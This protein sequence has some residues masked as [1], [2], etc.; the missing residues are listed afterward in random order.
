MNADKI[1]PSNWKKIIQG[2]K[3][4]LYITGISSL[5]QGRRKYIEKMKWVFCVFQQHPE[6]V[7][8]WRPHP[9]ELSTIKSIAPELEQL[10]LEVKQQYQS[11]N[12]GILDESAD[13]HRAIAVSDAYYGIWSSVVHLYKFTQKPILLQNDNI[14]ENKA[15]DI[16][17]F[18]ID[19]EYVWYIISDLNILFR[20]DIE[21]KKSLDVIVL[22]DE[23][24]C[25]PFANYNM[26]K[27]FDKIFLIPGTG[28]N[29]IVYEMTSGSVSKTKFGQTTQMIKFGAV[30]L[31]E[32]FLYLFP[33]MGNEIWKYDLQTQK[34]VKKI[35]FLF[36][37]K[38]DR[39]LCEKNNGVYF[40]NNDTIKRDSENAFFMD[41]V[42]DEISINLIS[43]QKNIYKGIMQYDENNFIL[44]SALKRE[45]V[46]W[47]KNTKKIEKIVDFPN[48]YIFDNSNDVQLFFMEKVQNNI[49]IF[50]N[51]RNS[52]LSLDVNSRKII[53][54]TKL[55]K[56]EIKLVKRQK[57]YIY[58]YSKTECC[59]FVINST[60]LQIEKKELQA[61]ENQKNIFSHL[62]LWEYTTSKEQD[63]LVGENATYFS[64]SNFIYTVAHFDN[65]TINKVNGHKMVGH[66]I[67]SIVNNI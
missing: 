9:L 65:S 45:I 49:Y 61:F 7:L 35:S 8:W 28:E 22:P 1:F 12:I 20:A 3:V 38:T 67:Y 21:D 59:F 24:I 58:I 66:E 54:V 10:Y 26:L 57:Q 34:I 15:W 48:D 19:G 17:D 32:D 31:W 51:V 30:Y 29:L 25:Q 14:S 39:V 56:Q 52:I 27:Y 55:G 18:V 62:N 42:K 4:I 5:L 33:Y 44:I 64:L 43:N 2:K 6:V 53:N 16:V 13:L 37:G 60:N 63:T 50:S 11:E 36:E 40:I 47:N 41:F 23:I 46:L